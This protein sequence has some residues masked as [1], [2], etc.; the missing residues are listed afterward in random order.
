MDMKLK[1]IAPPVADV[2][3]ARD[4]YKEL[5]WRQ[6]ADF[7][8]SPN[9]QVPGPDPDK[10]SYTSSASFCDPDGNCWLLQAITTRAPGR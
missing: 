6:D 2:G 7:S 4:S 5:G 9:S 3:R 8:G 1:V 10:R